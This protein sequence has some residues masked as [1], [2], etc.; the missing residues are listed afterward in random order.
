MLSSKVQSALN[1]QINAEFYAAYL[2]LSM[3]AHFETQSL[4]GF[5]SWMR[6]QAQEEV[7]HAMRI[8][9]FVNE[10]DGTVQLK[11]IKAPPGEWG[12]PLAAFQAAYKHEQW[13]TGQINKL[14]DLSL[15]EHDHATNTFLQWFVTE[16]IE[17]EAN[18]SEIVSNLK[19]VGDD[20]QGLFI[21]DRELGQ[22][23]PAAEEA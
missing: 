4:S 18:A 16:Q 6:L 17:E 23:Q 1:G 15:K 7:G 19:L 2:Y 12:G 3:S 5:A 11:Q 21:M 22:R 14:V 13:V 9:D 20:G 10:R 8:Y